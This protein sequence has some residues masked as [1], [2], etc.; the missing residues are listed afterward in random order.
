MR[1]Q[2]GYTIEPADLAIMSDAEVLEAARC[3]RISHA[4][5]SRDPPARST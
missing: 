4:S 2:S 1:T 3:A 5:A